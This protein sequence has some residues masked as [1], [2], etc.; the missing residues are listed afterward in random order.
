KKIEALY[1]Y[2]KDI[3]I[4]SRDI[5]TLPVV[6]TNLEKMCYSYNRCI[7]GMLGFDFLSLQKI[8]FNFVSHKMYIWK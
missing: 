1:G 5:T 8:G 6:V 7:D 2:M 4:G 3:K